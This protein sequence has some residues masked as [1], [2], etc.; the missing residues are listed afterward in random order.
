MNSGQPSM[1]DMSAEQKRALL[2]ELLRK[3]T[4]SVQEAFPLS[5]GQRALWFLHQLDPS[6]SAYNV[7]IA[8]RIQ[9]RVDHAAMQRAVEMLIGRHAA[10]RTVFEER[11][12]KPLQRIQADSAQSLQRI[13]L[14]GMAEA[15]F[16]DRIQEL[17]REPF[18]LLSPPWR[19]CLLQRRAEDQ[20]LLL[21]MH[22]IVTDYW[23]MLLLMDELAVLYQSAL[24][25]AESSLPPP[26]PGFDEHIRLQQAM[27]AGPR[28]E[29]QKAYW[30][31]RLSGRISPL[32]LPLDR[33][34]PSQLGF[35]GATFNFSLAPA[36]LSKLKKIARDHETTLYAVLAGAYAILLYRISRQNDIVIGTPTAGR[37]DRRFA[38]T[39]G[40]F[41]NPV[42]LRFALNGGQAFGNFLEGASRMIREALAHGD[43]PFA[44]LAEA[45]QP[46]R[47]A[48][49]SPIFQTMLVLQNA[50]GS[51]GGAALLASRSS[52]EPLLWG[53]L[54]SRF[55]KI[56]Q[57][58]GQFEIVLELTEENKGLH[59][60][61]NYNSDLFEP[62]SMEGFAR[63]FRTLLAG[64]A[65]DPD[66][67][68]DRL[69]LM[70]DAER[71]ALP[72]AGPAGPSSDFVPLHRQF[73]EWARRRPDATAVIHEGREY[74]YRELNTVANRVAYRLLAYDIRPEEPIAICIERS[75]TMLAA[76]LATL[77]VGAAYLPLDPG[78][79][80]MRLTAMLRDAGARLLIAMPS[81]AELF[82][83]E[84]VELIDA[85]QAGKDDASD[86]DTV[87]A[88]D[89]LV[90]VI[91][92]SGST[93]RPKAVGLSH[94]NLAFSTA[95][96]VQAY[97]GADCRFLL[98]SS[99]AFDSSVAG[100]FGT[101]A[102]GGAIVLPRQNEELE[103]DR[104]CEYIK[105]YEVTDIVCLPS[106]Y[107][108]LLERLA[109]TPPASLTNVIVAGESCPPELP[110]RH[111]QIL[112]SVALYNE[113]GPTEGCVWCTRIEL[114]GEE[115]DRS[116]SIGRPIGGVAIYILDRHWQQVPS[117]V[118]GEL[119]LAS[120]GLA[121]GYLGHP[122]RTAE[123]FLPNPFA[124]T[125]G[126]RLYCSG[127]LA[128][129]R[130]DGRIEFLG[131]VDQQ[132]KWRGYRIEPGEIE[133]AL[134]RRPQITQA[135][136]QLY[137][138]EGAHQQLVGYYVADP[139]S[140]LSSI[141]LR[142]QLMREL[143]DYMIPGKLV[144]IDRMPLLPNGK[145]D[146]AALPIP[147]APDSP[148]AAGRPGNEEE[149]TI[150]AIWCALL[151]REQL[152][153]HD[154][155]FDLGGHSLLLVEMQSKLRAHFKSVPS[156]VELFGMPTVAALAQHL[157][158][159]SEEQPKPAPLSARREAQPHDRLQDQTIAV[160][161]MAC[162][163]PGAATPEEFWRN[164]AEGKESIR[165][166]SPE[167]LA[168]AGLPAELIDH[169]DYVAARGALDNVESFDAQFF[170]LSP[171]EATLLDPQ[172]R[173]LLECA[174]EA[175]EHGGYC[176]E[177]SGERIGLY[178]GVG[179][180]SYLVNNLLADSSL[181]E[182]TGDYQLTISNDKDF[183]SSFAAYKLDL[184]GPAI[185]VQ[186]ACSTS[187]AAVHMACRALQSGDCDMA[188][189][190]GA[191]I[192]VPHQTGYMYQQGMIFARDGHCRPFDADASGTVVG[193][194]A[195]FVLLK[196]L[197]RAL[198]DGDSI[199]AVI[200]GS[201][202]NNDGSY[203]MGYTAPGI[204]GQARVIEAALD[205]AGV[206]ADQI[207]YVEAH[208][209][210]TTL[211]DPIEIQALSQAYRKHTERRRFC[212][213]GS[214]K[215]NVGHLNAAAGA[216]GL[217]KT[218]LALRQGQ[219]PPSLHFERPNPQ[220]DFDD[221][222]FFVNQTLRDWP[223][224]S[225][226]RLAGVSSFGIGGSNVHMILEK[227][228]PTTAIEPE[229]TGLSW[230]LPL[231]ARTESAV[232]QQCLQ[233]ADY[234]SAH[235]EV[236]LSSVAATLALGRRH[237]P[238]RRFVA[239]GDGEDLPSA[240]RRAAQQASRI[241][242]QDGR[243]P[244]MAMM[245]SGQGTQHR[246]MAAGL[247]RGNDGFRKL[248]DECCG[249]LEPLLGVDLRTLL[250]RNDSV[251][252]QNGR[253]TASLDQTVMAQPALFVVEYALAMTIIVLGLKPAALIGHSVGE[254]VA[255]AL[256]GVCSLP[257]ALA[258]VARRAQLMQDAPSGAMLAIEAPVAELE[259]YLGEELA[260]AAV[261][262]AGLTVL[263]GREEAIAALAD[264]L[265]LRSIESRRLHTS[266]AFHSALMDSAAKDFESFM[267]SVTLQPP[268]IPVISNVTGKQLTAA[269]ACDPIYWARHLRSTVRFADGL[270]TLFADGID[271]L[272]EVGPG[273]T[274]A[275]FARQHAQCPPGATIATTMPRPKDESNELQVLY[276]G[277]GTLWQRG[278][279]L[280]W[281]T[282]LPAEI[283]RVP[284][285]TYPFERRR[286]W[287][288]P[289]VETNGR[290]R[291]EAFGIRAAGAA[292]SSADSPPKRTAPQ[293]WLYAPLWRQ[294]LPSG[295]QTRAP[296]ACW[297]LF[298]N[299]DDMEERLSAVIADSDTPRVVRQALTFAHHP[300]RQEYEL[301]PAQA[302]HYAELLRGL[303][304][305]PLN[306]VFAWPLA[307]V[308]KWEAKASA[309][310]V[311]PA[312]LS[313][314]LLV[315][316]LAA[317]P[318]D[319]SIRLW[320]LT[321]AVFSIAGSETI[322]P[323]QAAFL[324]LC[325]AIPLEY[326]AIECRHIDID[327]SNFDAGTA[328]ALAGL[329]HEEKPLAAEHTSV[330]LRNGRRWRRSLES[331][332]RQTA[333]KPM[334]TFEGNYLITGGL[335]ALGLKLAEGF[336]AAGA[337]G[338]ALLQRSSFPAADEWERY[339][340]EH[341]DD[342]RVSRSIRRL[343][344]I[345]RGGCRLLLL[346]ADVGDIDALRP[347]L[348]ELRRK[349]GPLR[350]VVHAAGLPGASLIGNTSPEEVAALMTPKLGGAMN[351]LEVLQDEDLD[352]MALCSSM[353]SFQPAV[354]QSAYAAANACLDAL[355]NS[356]PAAFPI[357][358]INWYAWSGEGMA[359]ETK[360][361]DE[362][363]D[364]HRRIQAQAIRPD[365]GF[366]ALCAALDCGLPQVLV[367]PVA[368]VNTPGHE[369]AAPEAVLEA[370][371]ELALAAFDDGP[372]RGSAYSAPRDETEAMLVGLWQQML[373]IRHIGVDDDFFELGGHSLL[374]TRILTRLREGLRIEL[375][376]NTLF[377]Y[378]TIAR[379]ADYINSA[380]QGAGEG[381]ADSD[382][383]EQVEIE[384]G[385]I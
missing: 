137:P 236:T 367:S 16:R 280:D 379:L 315:Q 187:L 214:V 170:G 353:I 330:V 186:T 276:S 87:I 155:F 365:E 80:Q 260:L 32:D 281:R 278:V 64:I 123:R 115:S 279:T 106:L 331:L 259:R 286:Y 190:G 245:F 101:L 72:V 4:A 160:V 364:L 305:A 307:V 336:A 35:K 377:D 199:Q 235:P 200:R 74:S 227:A 308:E 27:L 225:G 349:L 77:K 314:Q 120:P 268:A 207:D 376:V 90:Y 363:R 7:V 252:E 231:S 49:R 124:A 130:S 52:E 217:L 302:T 298:G 37:G 296:E 23:S 145:I 383:R 321:D 144:A 205:K 240:L 111:R 5:S 327:G 119:Y 297:L 329:L 68:L 369:A 370:A 282:L 371:S 3:K 113:Y 112:A 45:L 224:K 196:P 54:R 348:R 285:P 237:L 361:P 91:Y 178:G 226:T 99:F 100:I 352:F 97:P 357:I 89:Q 381:S 380:K 43:F 238:E 356:T 242:A 239:V 213:V 76:M 96:R 271:T 122:A 335:G 191:S 338:L 167:E 109:V 29:Q 301:D 319:R 133:A 273:R 230:L 375:P 11:E 38:R 129:Y 249:V 24:E 295:R 46:Q 71:Q 220:I 70:S 323:A 143:P 180:S 81:T 62:E 310:A 254:I 55:Y 148:S 294:D 48:A 247:Y 58:E 232:R 15:E 256:A 102:R 193:D 255:A 306:L 203:K 42:V 265:K 215:S 153:I 198:A 40:Y 266:H 114:S 182:R 209:T 342:D 303:P 116:V 344:A 263:S 322:R 9:D 139:A 312:Y 63:Q 177:P 248:V 150:A 210:G 30:M 13:D 33:P 374:A 85:A 355:A 140:D 20:I 258:V 346:R 86:P 250:F 287:A 73:E 159:R 131:R 181:V 195:V 358:S 107:T 127:D 174:W 290:Q 318:P 293:E 19:I 304:P 197:K 328:E 351:L 354:G 78:F 184:R 88:P 12:G 10:L 39:V 98:L 56:D 141:D 93:G 262:A 257:D 246:A 272:L 289:P 368:P 2:E 66:C 343:Q 317:L 211:G 65:A 382:P 128:R 325:A 14:S 28:G 204:E 179:M 313:L 6:A 149:Q 142:A 136:V 384:E 158:R 21:S 8:L 366:P 192:V 334:R 163:V 251:A 189:A 183:A 234:L 22:H 121:R 25:G 110:R 299:G 222:P 161:G 219:I 206:S 162:R 261:N 146:R 291:G 212:A 47:S 339:L 275:T 176:G 83:D 372:N 75:M 69:P 337:R 95:V 185:T 92:T 218:I 360:L 51:A 108:F 359:A 350:A 154:N 208:G 284:L 57:Q 243:E 320:I 60:G 156:V 216:A 311:P 169:P 166:F 1:E 165:F 152:D 134:E 44:D 277:L 61:L 345:R 82:A 274:L 244:V 241:S 201:A 132:I 202:M 228:P 229:K 173:L 223:A 324:G 172:Q 332:P 378:P 117:G 341:A 59:G 168:A 188:L 171:A 36:L 94:A 373:G 267:R 269:E 292:I 26:G 175:L 53:G 157:R 50:A 333:S 17:A 233:L 326:P 316:A 221:S 300:G 253:Q 103:V 164:L 125:P 194:G 105:K 347:A 138:K 126:E 264:D 34:R 104:L 362:L 151:Q 385:E 270:A 135:F 79:P 67:P 118:P 31:Q 41:I 84:A 288:D 309:A 147:T 283:R 18:N 340:A